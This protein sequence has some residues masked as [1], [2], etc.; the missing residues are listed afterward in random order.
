VARQVSGLILL[1]LTVFS[2]GGLAYNLLDPPTVYAYLWELAVLSIIGLA[3][4]I[5]WT[6]SH[7]RAILLYGFASLVPVLVI[8][9]HQVSIVGG[10]H[11]S[12]QYAPVIGVAAVALLTGRARWTLAYTA[13]A[14]IVNGVTIVIYSDAGKAGELWAFTSTVGAL[15]V[16]GC[17]ML[18]DQRREQAII[19]RTQ[20]ELKGAM[21]DLGGELKEALHGTK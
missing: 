18:N 13:W 17:L 15:A 11:S 3:A 9:Y 7:T 6:R 20:S 8:M 16:Y 21:R 2:S 5:I 12:L 10:V 19:R 4:L 14:L 1:L